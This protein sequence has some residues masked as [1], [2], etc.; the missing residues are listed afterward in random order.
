MKLPEWKIQYANL[1]K[2]DCLEFTGQNHETQYKVIKAPKWL[3]NLIEKEKREAINE[4]KLRVSSL[5]A[6]DE[7]EWM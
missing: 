7:E 1:T 2:T 4:F 6:V 5:M 3:K